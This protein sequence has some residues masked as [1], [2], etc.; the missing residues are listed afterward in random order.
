M[1][2]AGGGGVT[3]PTP[4]SP[5]CFGR[6]WH[7][8]A[9]DAGRWLARLARPSLWDMRLASATLVVA[10]AASL[11][12]AAAPAQV[13]TLATGTFVAD[14]IDGA[15]L[16]LTDRVTDRDGTTYL[17]EFDR[18]VLSLRGGNRFRA[19]VRFRRTLYSRDP[20]GRNRPAPIQSM[21]VEGSYAIVAGAIHFT[22]DPS[23]DTGGLRMLAGRIEGPRR[24]SMPFDYRNGTADRHRTLHL[25]RSTDVL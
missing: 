14:R 7:P 13:P 6:R 25:V 4:P 21:T 2:C 10:V 16:P 18:L 11:M 23:K 9:T 8:A 24:L 17:V 1:R 20:R 3:I 15:P 22:P 12:P 19:S 5:A